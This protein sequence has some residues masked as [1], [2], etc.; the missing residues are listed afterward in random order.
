ME[1]EG[2]ENILEEL[3]FDFLNDPSY[4][5]EPTIISRDKL[6]LYNFKNKFTVAHLNA[7]F[8]PKNFVEFSE[9]VDKTNFDVFAVSET[10]LTKNT[11]KDRYTLNNFNI[12]R[13]DRVNKRGGGCAIF[14]RSHYQAKIIKTPCDK[15]I[16][17]CYGWR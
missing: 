8:L 6:N 9:I 1:T 13:R 14:C 12:F 2:L 5:L 17:K 4:D 11:P 7:S 3:N 15:E 10:W 16:L